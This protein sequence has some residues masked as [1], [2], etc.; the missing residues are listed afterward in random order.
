MS[1]IDFKITDLQ[2]IGTATQGHQEQWDA[3]WNHVRSN[4]SNV[5]AEAL[6]REPG[7]SLDQRT[8]EYHRKTQMYTEQLLMQ[9]NSVHKVANT[10]DETNSAMTRTIAG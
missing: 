4:L 3:I 5:A 6:S 10:A 9:A 2:S 8:A 7:G 1:T